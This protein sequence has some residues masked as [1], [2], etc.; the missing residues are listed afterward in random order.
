MSIYLG[1]RLTAILKISSF[2]TLSSPIPLYA[3]DTSDKTDNTN[4]EAETIIVTAAKKTLPA[5]VINREASVGIL[6]ELDY[7]DNP[8]NVTSYTNDAIQKQHARSVGGFINK[9]DASINALGSD[10]YAIDLMTVR[11]IFVSPIGT[12]VNGLPGMAGYHKIP[13]NGIESIEVTKGPAAML[14]G[15][16][17]TGSSG[18]DINLITKRA[19]YEPLNEFGV[20]YLSQK[21]FG[22]NTDLGRR[23][24]ANQEWG[25]RFNSDNRDGDGIR[26][27][28]D[29]TVSQNSLA[30]DYS[31]ERF[32]ASIDAMLNNSNQTA[33]RGVLMSDASQ[34]ATSI[35]GKIISP[36]DG[37][38]NF[39]QSWVKQKVRDRMI[40]GR[41]EADLTDSIMTYGT[42]GFA[43]NILNARNMGNW[44]VT[45]ALDS[46]A[47]V[48]S[49]KPGSISDFKTR[50]KTVS[51]EIGTTGLHYIGDTA[52]K[53][54]IAGTLSQYRENV[55]TSLYSAP[56]SCKKSTIYSVQDCEFDIDS[57]SPIAV[58]KNKINSRF[59]SIAIADTITFW[60]DR[61]QTTLGVRRQEIK[62]K[63]NSSGTKTEKRQKET[64]PSLG[65]VFKPIPSFSIYGN[66]IEALTQGEIAPTTAINSGE[67]MNP[68]K[69]KQKEVGIKKEFGLWT[70]SVA[71][72]EIE[73]ASG[74][75]DYDTLVYSSAGKRRNRGIE[76]NLS[77]EPVEGLRLNSSTSWIRSKRVDYDSTSFSN[78]SV[79]PAPKFSSKLNVE[80]DVPRTDKITLLGT[81][82][83]TGK[84]SIDGQDF[85]T[86]NLVPTEVPAWTRVDLGLSYASKKL[87]GKETRVSLMVE[88]V[89]DK[90]YWS[91]SDYNDSNVVVLDHAEP[92]T[93]ILSL[94][95]RF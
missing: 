84:A 12:S 35:N 64:T 20:S 75:L 89:F 13:T 16:S 71:V 48:G 59:A 22:F 73:K 5:G 74:L 26:D 52:H 38:T 78:S 9:Y 31:G 19:G 27:K 25:I 6:G 85:Y 24:G 1:K 56:D 51:S 67:L 23:F 47:E 72:F 3:N 60:G 49:F 79:F 80:W 91:V 55:G 46:N 37:E 39:D 63:T 66:Y 50:R 45:K 44:F 30:L 28:Q 65:I 93:F 29:E 90:R 54:S 62:N 2:I 40:M 43:K 70:T 34:A 86:G 17:I 36:P 53:W 82:I 68:Y 14:K 15:S 76:F 4:E 77:G 10:S 83:H 42:I 8:Y 95:T 92:R 88:N 61:I 18:G 11:G 94:T 32:R 21:R 81:V 33:N 57:S 7:M 58:V 41:V 69:T 87:L